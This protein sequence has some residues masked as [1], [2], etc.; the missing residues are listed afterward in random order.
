MIV[1]QVEQPVISP[2]VGVC[3]LNSD[4]ICLGCGRSLQDVADWSAADEAT[5]AQIVR[6]ARQRMQEFEALDNNLV[7]SA[8]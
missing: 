4:E 5:R 2:C 3:E 7:R 6:Q 8:I 1:S